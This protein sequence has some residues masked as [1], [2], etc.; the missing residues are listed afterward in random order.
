VRTRAAASFEALLEA[1]QRHG[2]VR[3]LAQK[4]LAKIEWDA[5]RFA[6]FLKERRVRDPRA[7]R[8]DHVACWLSALSSKTSAWGRPLSSQTLRSR[9]H[10]IKRLY[11]FATAAG[12]VLGHPCS[13]L[14]SPPLLSLPRRVLSVSE[15]R[16]LVSH[17]MPS[18]VHGL[19]DRAV[20]ELL[21]GCGLRVSECAGLD[22]TDCDLALAQLLI[23]NAKG[24]KDRIVPIPALALRALDLYLRE[25]RP[26]LDRGPRENPALFLSQR[27]GRLQSGGIQHLVVRHARAA[28]IQGRCGPHAL[29]HSCATHLLKGGAD[30]R[31]V[32]A[33]LGHSDIRST[34][35]YTHVAVK[36]LEEALQKAHPR[37]REKDL[38]RTRRELQ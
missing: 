3:G 15:A 2:R 26:Q 17:P 27:K 29:R 23:R 4:T 14:V 19:R 33:F 34:A 22:L 21:Y 12:L 8:E 31:H 32:Q 11:D 5:K 10:S 36:D 30:I 20:L 35:V 6:R 7:V 16:R 38:G 1:Y 37:E 25:S 24:R 9:F 13:D 18:G 28:G